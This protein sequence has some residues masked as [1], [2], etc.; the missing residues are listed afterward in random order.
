METSATT[1]TT[2]KREKTILVLRSVFQS[3]AWLQEEYGELMAL[4]ARE[5]GCALCVCAPDSDA[6]VCARAAAADADTVLVATGGVESLFVELMPH[7]ARDGRPLALLADGRNNSLAAAL[8]ILTYLRAHARAGRIVHAPTNPELVHSLLHPAATADA[9]PQEEEPEAEAEAEAESAPAAPSAEAG[10]LAGCRVA[11]VGRPS[12]WLVASDVDRGVL[13][14]RYGVAVVDVPL[15]AVVA[16]YEGVD[17]A[18][19]DA[20]VAEYMAHVAFVTEPAREDIARSLRLYAALRDLCAAERVCALT[21][22][23][24]DIVGRLGATACVALSMLND[25]GIVA[26]CEGDMQALLTMLLARRLLRAPAFMANPSRVA[27]DATVLAHC[28]VPRTMCTAL[29]LRSHFESGRGVAPQGTLPAGP[30]VPP[31]T[32]VKW[33]GAALDRAVVAEAAALP[34]AAAAHDE[35]LC[36]TQVTLALDARAYLLARPIGNHHILVAGPHAAALRAFFRAHGVRVL[37]C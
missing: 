25:E 19:V 37:S 33:G 14:A 15:D 20:L 18:R 1:T 24:F 36:R 5:T 12:D 2:T 32:L 6:A 31:Y 26:G 23:C 27:A 17:A 7:L 30:A 10:V 34:V 9:A 3:D 35:H 13:A 21:V 4:L 11:C 22:R 16:R 29:A 28:T 8:E